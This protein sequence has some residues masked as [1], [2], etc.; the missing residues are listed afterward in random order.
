[1]ALTTELLLTR[2]G[3]AACNVAGIA[4]GDRSCTG[5]TPRG[6]RQVEHLAARLATEH[7]QRPFDVIY[8]TPRRRVR[9]TAEIITRALSLPATAL[10]DLRG[11]DHGQA[12]GRGWR[13]IKT[14][15]GGPPQHD[16]DRPYA[17]GAEP[18]NAYLERATR[19]LQEILTRHEGQRILLPAHGE[20]I[21]AA[22]TLLLGLTPGTCRHA[23]FITDHACLTRWQRHLN[24]LGQVVWLLAAHNDTSH[25]AAGDLL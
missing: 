20:T 4:G 12:D 14:A 6:R 11:P 9:Q 3:E 19:A 16:P 13:E 17:P 8:T 15:F 23:G 22:H 25:L 18:W 7:A 21:H 10:A 1:M 5:L 24:R 2:H